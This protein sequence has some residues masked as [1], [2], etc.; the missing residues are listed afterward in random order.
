MLVS[1]SRNKLRKE[2]QRRLFLGYRN[3]KGYLQY[4][5]LLTPWNQGL[6]CVSYSKEMGEKS[7]NGFLASV[8]TI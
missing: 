1:E 7:N 8:S 6:K 2:K 4:E 5:T 3:E